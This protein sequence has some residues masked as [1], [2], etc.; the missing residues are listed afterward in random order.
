MIPHGKK[1][2]QD[3]YIFTGSAVYGEG[4]HDIFYAETRRDAFRRLID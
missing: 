3:L 1:D 2:E 4:K